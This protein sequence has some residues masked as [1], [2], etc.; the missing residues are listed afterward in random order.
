MRVRKNA[1]NNAVEEAYTEIRSGVEAKGAEIERAEVEARAWGEADIME[2]SERTKADAGSNAKY[3]TEA[4][5]GARAWS[6]AEVT[7]KAEIAGV[8]V[9]DREKSESEAAERAKS[10]AEAS[11]SSRSPG[12]LMRRVKRWRLRQR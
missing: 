11:R 1:A 10:W 3:E 4:A 5:D 7:E 9:E 12:S 8:A 2:E 6:E